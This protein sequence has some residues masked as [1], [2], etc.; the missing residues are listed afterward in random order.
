MRS[1]REKLGMKIEVK[2]MLSEGEIERETYILHMKLYEAE[3][4][5][6]DPKVPHASEGTQYVEWRWAEPEELEEAAS[7]G[8]LCSRLFLERLGKR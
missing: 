6:G 3:I 7:K 5:E 8:S 2:G 4:A 1:G